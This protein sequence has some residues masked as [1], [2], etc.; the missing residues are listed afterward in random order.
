M[1][2]TGWEKLSSQEVSCGKADQIESETATV[3]VSKNLA[4][5]PEG[6]TDAT[7]GDLVKLKRGYDLPAQDRV[8]DGDIQIIGGGG[9]NGFHNVAK[10]PT[11]GIVIGRSGAGIGKAWW[12]DEPFW[13][14]NTGLYV[15]DFQ[16]NDPRFCFS[17]LDWIDFRSYN[18][19]GAQPSLNR[20]FIYPIQIPLPPLPEQRKIAEILGTWDRAIE[21]TSALLASARTRKRGLM[22]ILLTGKC[23]FPE[24]KG[25]AW[26]EV[27]LG[28]VVRLSK[29][30]FDPK[31]EHNDRCCIELEHIEPGTGRLLGSTQSNQQASTKAIFKP[32]DVLFGKLRPYLRKFIA[33]DFAGVCST[34][35]WV[36]QPKTQAVTSRFLHCLVQ[37]DGF[38]AEADKS[39]GSRMPRADWKIV[40]DYCFLLPSL[41]EQD[42][43]TST[44]DLCA[45]E[46]NA[47]TNK[48]ERLHTQKKALMQKL[49]TGEWRVKV[50][51]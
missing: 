36:L 46:V 11:P 51:A 37:S 27:R 12:S 1:M 6:W 15:T 9:P 3:N 39:S 10:A 2:D 7:L 26:R 4:M 8:M 34:E 29:E 40:S 17:L 47:L 33:P 50:D 32:G 41:N 13:P 43:I 20:N 45:Q 35:I 14:L 48:I 18:T 5:V 42:R 31:Q 28:E 23:R 24:F 25:Q 30:R 22:Q 21:L 49:L 38:M 19:G 16:A 44:L